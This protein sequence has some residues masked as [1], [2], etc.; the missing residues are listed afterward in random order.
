MWVMI[1]THPLYIATFFLVIAIFVLYYL[2]RYYYEYYYTIKPLNMIA[3]VVES[4]DVTGTMNRDGAVNDSRSI[5]NRMNQGIEE[6]TKDNKERIVLLN[7]SDIYAQ[8]NHNNLQ[9]YTTFSQVSSVEDI[10]NEEGVDRSCSSSSSSSNEKKK[11]NK[12][13]I[14]C[15]DDHGSERAEEEEDDE[16]S[17]ESFTSESYSDSSFASLSM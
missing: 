10:V 2:Y 5:K 13:E 6:E 11:E 15:R 3:P 4:G 14:L 1:A 9:K 12:E 16:C 7:H 17:D 8:T